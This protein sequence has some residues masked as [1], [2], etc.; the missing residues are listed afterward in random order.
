MPTPKISIPVAQSYE[1]LVQAVNP[2]SANAPES[3]PWWFYDTQLYTSAATVQQ[4]FFAATQAARDLSNLPTGGSLPD[5]NFMA[6]D[7]IS[8]DFMQNAAGTPYTTTAAIGA[9]VTNPNALNDV[10]SLLLSGRARLTLT[11]SDKQYGP[12]PLSVTGG[13]GAAQGFIA[14]AG[15]TGAGN[16]QRSDFGYNALGGAYIGGKII[17]PPKVGFSAV[18]DWPA[19]LTLTGNYQVRLVLGG[20]YYRRIL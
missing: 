11:I 8:V 12:W 2:R 19:A 14:I 1:Q 9:A 15:L 16:A 7:Y 20:V 4:T 17:I 18:I 3:V 10:G 5:P 13:T 6:I